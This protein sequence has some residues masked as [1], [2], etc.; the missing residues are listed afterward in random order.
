MQ[1]PRKRRAGLRLLLALS[2]LLAS[3]AH[4]AP[5]AVVER[6]DV[7]VLSSK[8]FVSVHLTGE[9]PSDVEERLA[10]GQDTAFEYLVQLRRSRK[11]F[12]DKTVFERYV[13]VT[14]RY[15]S[16]TRM[17][18]LS[19]RVDG[20]VVDSELTDRES[21]MRQWMVE[22][23]ELGLFDVADFE[24]AGSHYVRV[25]V[26]LQSRYKLLFVPADVETEWRESERFEPPPGQP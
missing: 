7:S 19:R 18:S 22:L 21:V 6:V 8:V 5:S 16:L 20:T 25:K 4:A 13:V 17:Y 3:N 14:A 11:N 2:G 12:A 23:L 10:A 26:K 1:Q 24:A 15:N 9:L